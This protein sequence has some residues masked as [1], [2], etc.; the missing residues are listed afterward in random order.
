MQASKVISGIQQIGIGVSNVYMAWEWYYKNFGFDIKMFEEEAIADLMLPYT[1]GQPMERHAL[2]AINIQGGGG[3]EIWQYTKRTPLAPLFNIQCGDLGIFAVKIKTRNPQAV[4]EQYKQQD[5]NIVTDITNNPANGKSFFIQD[6]FG[7]YF[8]IV[9]GNSWFGKNGSLTGG[10][11][12]AVI[13]V[14]NIQ[15]SVDFY[16]NILG[17]DEVIYD[18]TDSFSDFYDLPGGKNRLKRVLLRHSSPR[19]GAFSPLFGSSE[20]ELVQTTAMTPRKIYDKRF[21]GDLGFMHLCFDIRGM[22]LL[23]QECI[24]HDCPFTVDSGDTFDMGEAAGAFSYTEDPDGT[25]IEFV[26]THRIPIHKKFGWYLN[27]K[28]R[29]PEKALPK[30]LLKSLKFNRVKKLKVSA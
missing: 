5:I 14:S 30:W 27:L 18:E 25:L 2:L 28:K 11:Y 15:K 6:P 19:Q 20:I 12:G 21:W 22:D 17:Y 1:G 29:K 24:N 10:A 4:Y 9:E 16:K 8:Q 7:N 3:F 23:R 26:E 13:G